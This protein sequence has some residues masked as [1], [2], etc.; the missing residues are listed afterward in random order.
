MKASQLGWSPKV[1]DK[2]THG[3]IPSAAGLQSLM[4]PALGFESWLIISL[5]LDKEHLTF[6][7][8]VRVYKCV[9]THE[10]ICVC[11]CICAVCECTVSQFPFIKKPFVLIGATAMPVYL[12]WPD[13]DPLVSQGHRLRLRQL[14]PHPFVEGDTTQPMSSFHNKEGLYLILSTL[15]IKLVCP[16]INKF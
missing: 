16:K 13:E 15:K 1:W 4:Q 2:G 14:G 12:C 6:C 10:Y 3:L 9:C 11:V 5:G 7:F 8:H